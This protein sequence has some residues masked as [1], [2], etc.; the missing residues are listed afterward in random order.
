[1]KSISFRPA[2]VAAVITASGLIAAP[3]FAETVTYSASLKGSDE[4]PAN[5]AK[6]TGTVDAS[7]DTATKKMTYTVTYSGLSGAATAAHFHG[8]AEAG[9]NAPPIV[10]V[11]AGKLASPIKGEATL[12]DAQLAEFSGGKVYFNLHT[13]A[14]KDGELR[15]QVMKK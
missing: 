7:V 5:D 8:P 2:I 9:K 12:S 3:A 15:G 13:A 11:P 10:P 1:M 14:H 4:V 6:G